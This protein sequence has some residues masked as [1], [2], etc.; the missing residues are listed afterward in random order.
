MR[1]T[2]RKK[3]VVSRSSRGMQE[4]LIIYTTAA[5]SRYL[6][7]V[8]ISTNTERLGVARSKDR[9]DYEGIYKRTQILSQ[10]PL[11]RA[12]DSLVIFL[13]RSVVRE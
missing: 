12:Q 7:S 10:V 3:H 6:N 4:D 2:E 5:S 1:F 13:R 11:S 9:Q 8:D